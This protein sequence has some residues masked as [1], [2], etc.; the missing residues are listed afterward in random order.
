VEERIRDV[1]STDRK[2]VLFTAFNDGLN[3][4][5]AV[6]GG[7]CVTISGS[8]NAEQRMQ[9]VDRF[10]TDPE[11][12]VAICNIIAGGVGMVFQ[13][14]QVPACISAKRTGHSC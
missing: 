1:I 10:Q 11:V 7:E 14:Y 9:A 2:V 3:K 6:F 13:H 12:R 8:D 5:K 4:H